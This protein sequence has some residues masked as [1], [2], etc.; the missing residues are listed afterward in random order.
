MYQN[1]IWSDI[2]LVS[3]SYR[4]QYEA[5]GSVLNCPVRLRVGS[6]NFYLYSAS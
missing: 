2:R 1:V 5:L 3:R 6:N 4:Y